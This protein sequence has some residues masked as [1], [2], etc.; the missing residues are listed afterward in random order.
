MKVWNFFLFSLSFSQEIERRKKSCRQSSKYSYQS[1]LLKYTETLLP[2]DG[3]YEFVYSA[4]VGPRYSIQA[5]ED[6]PPSEKW[7]AN[8]GREVMH[9]AGIF[10]KMGVILNY[11]KLPAHPVKTGQARRGFPERKLH[12]DCAP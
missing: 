2:T 11:V 1:A 6:A 8:K 4:L 10:V 5:A 9:Y 12:F 3:I 7:V